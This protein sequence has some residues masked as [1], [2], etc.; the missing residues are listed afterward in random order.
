MWLDKGYEKIQQ[1]EGKNQCSK[2]QQSP[3]FSLSILFDIL[4]LKKKIV[5]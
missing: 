5:E 1:V 3:S 2:S 4:K